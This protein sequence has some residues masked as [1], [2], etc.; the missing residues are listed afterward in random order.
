MAAGRFLVLCA[1]SGTLL[2]LTSAAGA[3]ADDRRTCAE[4]SGDV[5]IA[6][7]SRMIASGRYRGSELAKAYY[8]RGV[9]YRDKGDLDRAL[10]DLNQAIRLD[11]KFALAYNNRGLAW[12]DKG[13][14]DR[15]LADYNEAIRLDPKL[16]LPYV[17]QGLVSHRRGELDRALA[18]YDEAIRLDSKFAQ[19]YYNRARAWRD[20]G[21]LDRALADYTEALELNPLPK[22]P[23]HVNVYVDRGTLWRAKGDLDRAIADYNDAIRFDPKYATAYRARG[24]AWRDK[25]GANVDRALVDYN[26]AIRLD[27]KDSTAY[28]NRGVTYLYN[29]DAARALADVNQASELDP[30]DAYHALWVDIVGQRNGVASRLEQA[31][32]KLDMTKWP[33]PVLRLFLG[34]LTPGAAVL[35]AADN[36]DAK[37][38]SNQICEANF[39]S[40]IVALR[41][42]AKDEAAKLYRSAADA[43]PRDVIEWYAAHAELKQ[44]GG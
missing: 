25:G 10:A 41:T 1:V 9:E 16:A 38:K 36:P 22:S 13:E 6:A 27:S 11:P 3:P 24:D 44:L 43:C 18:D 8:F 30:K 39:Y 2:A 33:G 12:E 37:K 40:G 26:E 28:R 5:A 34:Q 23:T 4:V 20:K 17:N 29:G 14:L 7:C 31:I 35:A 19:A 15:A 32:A 42:G 21:E